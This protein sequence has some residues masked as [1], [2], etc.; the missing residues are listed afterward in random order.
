MDV[1]T[2]CRYYKGYIPCKPHKKEGVHCDNCKY[3]DP[4][5]QRFLIIKLAAIGDVIR[6]TP[7]LHKLKKEF[8]NAEI[9]WLTYSPAILPSG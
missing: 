6:T 7:L 9:N 2:D 1:K 5:K 8:P 3:Y 4:I